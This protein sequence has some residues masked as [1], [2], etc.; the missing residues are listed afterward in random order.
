MIV[1]QRW[2]VYEVILVRPDD[3]SVGRMAAHIKEAVESWGGQFDPEDP[4]F[5]PWSRG[6]HKAPYLPAIRVR[7]NNR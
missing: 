6:R 7:R 5:N 2:E 3:V 4:L 1:K